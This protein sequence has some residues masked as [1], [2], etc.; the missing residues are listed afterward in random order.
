MREQHTEKVI[1]TGKDPVRPGERVIAA[2]EKKYG[3]VAVCAGEGISAVFRDIGA[4]QVVEGGQTMNPSTE[5]I[6]RAIDR[7][8]AEIV[9]VF[10]NNKNIIMAAEQCIS[11][12]EK[13]VVIIPTKTI[14]QG[15]SALLNFDPELEISQ[16]RE[17]MQEAI[18]RVRTGQVTYASRDSIFDGKRIKEGDYLAILDGELISSNK[19]ISAVARKLARDMSR[20]PAEFLTIFYGSDVTE[21]EAEEVRA[22]FEKEFKN[23]EINMLS[24]GQPVYYYLVSAE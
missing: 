4:D 18:S 7:T 16:N 11:M 12:S 17:K 9:L 8:P 1:I 24:G 6:L 3:I 22:I 2:P 10:P 15:I 20:K 23:A 21:A 5:D 14:P 19:L 13:T